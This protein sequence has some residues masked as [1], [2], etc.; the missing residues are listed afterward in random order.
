L[1][2]SNVTYNEIGSSVPRSSK[3][4][5]KLRVLCKFSEFFYSITKESNTVYSY[6]NFDNIDNI[7]ARVN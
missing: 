5:K 6:Q 3:Y 7:L 1:Q 4:V 2:T